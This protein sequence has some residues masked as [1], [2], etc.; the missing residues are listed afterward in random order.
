MLA[1][2]ALRDLST[3]RIIKRIGGKM[4]EESRDIIEV[5]LPECVRALLRNLA[6]MDRSGKVAT[7]CAT[8]ERP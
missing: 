4:R 8:P 5:E 3:N 1:R 2:G 6:S 7:E